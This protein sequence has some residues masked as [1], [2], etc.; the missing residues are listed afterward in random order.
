M[1]NKKFTLLN[2]FRV[3]GY[4]SEEIIPAGGLGAVSAQAGVG[5][6]ALLVQLAINSML[7]GKKVLH[8]SL[9]DPV[10]KVSLWYNE[11]FNNIARQ[12]G[13]EGLN[14]TW[15]AILPNRLIMTFKVEGFNVPKLK[16]RLYD[17]IVQNIFLPEIIIIDGLKFNN[18][19]ASETIESLKAMAEKHA[20]RLWFTVHTRPKEEPGDVPP[21]LLPLLHLFDCVFTLQHERGEICI[22]PLS[23]RAVAVKPLSLDPATMLIKNQALTAS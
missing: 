22:K 19:E 23:G 17:L 11:L 21:S 6:T 13:L 16:E 3:M 9:N 1:L 2:P 7:R 12:A 8:I 20:M 15:E 5:K 18:K 10:N 4:E 14:E